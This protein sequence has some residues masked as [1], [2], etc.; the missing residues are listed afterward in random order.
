[1]SCW[2]APG[3]PF[4]QLHVDLPEHPEIDSDTPGGGAVIGS[5]NLDFTIERRGMTKSEICLVP[6]TG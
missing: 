6:S 2:V 4:C 5:G 1:M 3:I